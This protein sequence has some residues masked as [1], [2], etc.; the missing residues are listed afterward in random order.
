MQTCQ[1]KN[2]RY[3]EYHTTRYHCCGSCNQT[4]HGQNECH[5]TSAKERL[6][7]HLGDNVPDYLECQSMVCNDPR[8][9]QNSGHLC[10][11]CQGR[12]FEKNCSRRHQFYLITC[13]LC[14]YP[15]LIYK[16]QIIIKGLTEHCVVCQ[17]N[18]IEIYFPNCGHTTICRHC[19][20]RMDGGD[21]CPP[22]SV[23]FEMADPPVSDIADEDPMTE[24]MNRA[25]EQMNGHDGKVWFVRPTGMGC[26]Y[27]FRRNSPA[28]PIEYLFMHSDN[29]GQYGIE[30]DDRPKLAIFISGY[31]EIT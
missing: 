24:L 25:R 6:K 28:D 21:V 23:G 13:P 9:H 26:C 2:C 10:H 3:S 7:L 16:S 4:G 17:S 29:W 8:S 20:E 5:S 15:N 19:L 18:P 27:Y 14:R 12:H 11:V 22:P 30:T 31:Q 1:V